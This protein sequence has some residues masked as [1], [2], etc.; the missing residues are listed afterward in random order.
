MS[1]CVCVCFS[2]IVYVCVCVCVCV[3]C[4]YVFVFLLGD[5]LPPSMVCIFYTIT[6][7]LSPSLLHLIPGSLTSPVKKKRKV[8]PC[9]LLLPYQIAILSDE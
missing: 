7:P 9:V 8:C 6:V 5:S 2:S 3:M 1:V 4:T